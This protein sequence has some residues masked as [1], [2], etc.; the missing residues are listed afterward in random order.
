MIIIFFEIVLDEAHKYLTNNPAS[1]RLTSSIISLIRQQRHFG[2]RTIISTQEPTIVPHS[3]L[4]LASILIIHRFT[5]PSWATHLA[6]HFNPSNS[7]DQDWFS[8]II[9]LR[10]GEALILAPSGLGLSQA[11]NLVPFADGFLWVRTRRRLT[12]DGGC[13]L[14]ACDEDRSLSHPLVPKSYSSSPAPQAGGGW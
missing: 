11:S 3:I 5:S 9:R 12:L 6:R 13:S 14:S 8:K 10:L 1:E 2:I 4:D 7:D